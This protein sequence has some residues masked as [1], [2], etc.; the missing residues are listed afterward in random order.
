M[1]QDAAAKV[2]F[3]T[4]LKELRKRS[5]AV[6]STID[7][8][9]TPHAVGVEYGVAPSGGA[10]YV[11]TRKHLKKAR[12][13]AADPHVALVVPLTRRL[14]WFLPPPSIQFQGTAEIVDRSDQEGLRTFQTFFMG[15]RILKMYEEF[16]RR[17]ETRVCFLR[18]VPEP[19][20]STYMVGHSIWELSRRMEVGI[21]KVEVPA[22]YRPRTA[23]TT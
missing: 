1:G 11:M 17:G 2:T 20:I 23:I 3:E 4:V 14:L 13:I 18:I 6:L 8:Q 10:I 19:E 7:E 16:E 15:R 22:Q 9:G 12:N 5:F 21:G